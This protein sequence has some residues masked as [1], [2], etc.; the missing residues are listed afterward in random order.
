MAFI[1]KL[2]ILVSMRIYLGSDHNG[3]HLKEKLFAYL[4]KRNYDV[5]VVGDQELDPDDDFPQFA[6][7]AAL[8]VIG[9]DDSDPRAILICGGGQGMCMA[10][11]RFRGIRASV[12]WDAYEAKMTR[13][14]NDSNVLCLPARILQ[15]DEKAWQGIVET[16]LSTPFADA[17]RFRRRNQQLDEAI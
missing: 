8:K 15:D 11:N 16:W 14:D 12:I 10:A 7:M 3:Y 13:H 4:A 17:P 9:D 2:L 5:E 1:L 6:Q